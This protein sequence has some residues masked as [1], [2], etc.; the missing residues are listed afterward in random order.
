MYKTIHVFEKRI[1]ILYHTRK[2]VTM[3]T[4]SV[5]YIRMFTYMSASRAC[6]FN[7]HESSSVRNAFTAQLIITPEF[8][9][10][11]RLTVSLQEQ[12]RTKG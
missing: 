2:E 12:Q 3:E 7:N 4:K 11:H 9:M 10:T 1:G 6:T 8:Y 5:R